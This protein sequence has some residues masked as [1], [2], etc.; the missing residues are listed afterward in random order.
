MVPGFWLSC[1]SE[2]L[3]R[4]GRK[5]RG[6]L[7]GTPGSACQQF[8]SSQMPLSTELPSCAHISASRELRKDGGGGGGGVAKRACAARAPKAKSCATSCGLWHVLR[9]ALHHV[10]RHVLRS[11]L[12]KSCATS[13][14]CLPPRVAQGQRGGR[15]ACVG[16]GFRRWKITMGKIKTFTPP[17]SA[18]PDMSCAKSCAT[19]CATFFTGEQFKFRSILLNLT[20]P[21]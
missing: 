13:F 6:S 3:A 15:H 21:H 17:S 5:H 1:P 10:L 8:S 7:R 20:K 19:S 12:A 11:P 9:K 14:T 2:A 16:R 4:K 18:A